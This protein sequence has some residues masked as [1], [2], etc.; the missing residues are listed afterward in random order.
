MQHCLNEKEEKSIT[1]I[2][3]LIVK[4]YAEKIAVEAGTERI[5]YT[6]LNRKSN[7]V[8]HMLREKGVGKED[9]VAIFVD[10]SIQTISCILGILKAGAAYLPIDMLL[11]NSRIK[12]M[13]QKGN[14]K[15]IMN[16]EL[17]RNELKTML[18]GC[19]ISIIDNYEWK[20]CPQSAVDGQREKNSLAYVMYTSG[21]EGSPK[22]VMIEDK[23]I[24]RL[25]VKEDYFPFSSEWNILQSST[26]VFDASVFEVFGSLLNGA[27]LHLIKTETLL[28]GEELKHW[29]EKQPIDLMF[30]TTPLF[31]QLVNVDVSIFDSVRNLVVGGDVLLSEPV[32]RLKEYNSTI[33]LFNGYGPTENTTFST[34]YEVPSEIPDNIPIGKAISCSTTYIW[35]EKQEP[36]KLGEVGELYVG[37]EGVGRGYIH[38]EKM[39]EEKFIR[40]PKTGERLYR[41]GDL[42]K[43]NGD[44]NIEF[45]GR[46]DSQIKIRGFRIELQEIQNTINKLTSVR[47]CAVICEV[48]GGEKILKAYLALKKTVRI[49]E[50]QKQLR[51]KLPS[52]MIP[53]KMIII[54]HLPLNSN[55]KIDKQKLTQTNQGKKEQH[56][57]ELLE[58]NT[59]EA[60][61]EA[62]DEEIRVISILNQQ[63]QQRVSL[64]DD[65][66]EIGFNSITAVKILSALRKQG[67][68]VNIKEILNVRTVRDMLD[69][70]LQ[71][72]SA[73]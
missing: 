69:M 67:Y 36:V 32:R 58:I 16:I 51:E 15:F 45:M 31:H 40:H 55:G 73:E 57:M 65:L 14:I 64:E 41:T 29:L 33:H 28:N 13:L 30:L 38:N 62:C 11:P 1:R 24:I 17:V 2:F 66:Y 42:A 37:G 56:K 6:E 5:S 20:K 34:F 35:N 72:R 59:S 54:D 63:L 19:D 48:C 8:A 46:V 23:G 39:T 70:I 60:S 43:W 21:S 7:Q 49:E 12:Y 68:M 27:T 71:K 10:K 25:V 9:I 44:G 50:L 52:Y 53:H 47:E 18:Q 26:L 4:R 22:G 3:E 61:Q